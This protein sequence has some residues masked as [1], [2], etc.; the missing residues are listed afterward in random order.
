MKQG[1]VS[2]GCVSNVDQL[3]VQGQNVIYSHSKTDEKSL[4]SLES[5]HTHLVFIDDG[6]KHDH[7]CAMK[8]RGLLEK[9]LL[10]E[11]FSIPRS[12]SLQLG[13]LIP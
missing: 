3:D 11:R 7:S 1:I 2:W 4:L 9:V 8:F 13:E 10:N 12:N 5:N 6:S